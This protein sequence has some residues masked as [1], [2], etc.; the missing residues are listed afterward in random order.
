[1]M[2]ITGLVA[3]APLVPA[4]I[5]QDTVYAAYV[6]HRHGDRT[7]KSLPPANLTTLGY[8]QVIS[9]GS[10]FH[11]RFVDSSSPNHIAG[12]STGLVKTS[13]LSVSAPLDTVLQNSAQAFLQ[14]LYPPVGTQTETL[15][16]GSTI[17]APFNGY[18]LIPV[19]LV[20]AGTGSEDNG[21]LQ[22]AS[23]CQNAKISSNKYFASNEY[24]KLLSSTKD[25]Y[26]R[27]SP[28]VNQTFDSDYMT[29]KNA[30]TS[31]PHSRQERAV[32][33]TSANISQSSTS[34]TSP[35]S[36]TARFKHPVFSTPLLWSPFRC[37]RTSMNTA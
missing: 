26:T 2:L 22:D 34:S 12:L 6:F 15:A 3:L 17:N 28:V 5:G 23:G 11:D 25:F 27:L 33:S 14:G 7:P 4:V 31:E 21:W 16:N 24:Q 32:S 18:Q 30:Y 35:V 20:D 19:S 36:T 13:Q 9:A 1:M 10:Y 37:W 8:D 29:Y